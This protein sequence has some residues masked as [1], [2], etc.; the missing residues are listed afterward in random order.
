MKRCESCGAPPALCLCPRY[1]YGLGNIAGDETDMLDVDEPRTCR[2]CGCTDMNCSQCVEKTG[3]PC[4]W[5]R[6]EG[7]GDFTEPLCSA[8]CEVLCNGCAWKGARKELDWE[9]EPDRR[10][11]CCPRC[12]SYDLLGINEYPDD[13]PRIDDQIAWEA[14]AKH[15]PDLWR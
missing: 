14:S 15:D 9:D 12:M 6:Q 3:H 10:I 2:L 7:G 13:G 4:S 11:H 5:V 1:I 8:C